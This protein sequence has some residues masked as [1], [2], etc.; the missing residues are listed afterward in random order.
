MLEEFLV[1]YRNMFSTQ[2]AVCTKCA[3][4]FV[5]RIEKGLPRMQS[6]TCYTCLKTICQTC[7]AEH[8]AETNYEITEYCHWCLRVHCEDCMKKAFCKPYGQWFCRDRCGRGRVR[9][10]HHCTD[11]K[12]C[13]QC[14]DAVCGRCVFE[15]TCRICNVAD[16]GG[17][18]GEWPYV[19]ECNICCR[20]FCFD[21][22]S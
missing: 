21:C 1:R 3:A 13:S 20:S 12:D 22:V 19:E 18:R 8:R 7:N 14:T 5:P 11:Y 6:N 10:K 9:T 4:T 16:C 17:C 15:R 2:R